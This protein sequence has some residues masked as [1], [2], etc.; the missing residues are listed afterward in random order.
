MEGSGDLTA[1]S[2]SHGTSKVGFGGDAQNDRKEPQPDHQSAP[3][4]NANLQR[5]PG[6]ARGLNLLQAG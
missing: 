5:R 2:A 6:R 1:S 4:A 3:A